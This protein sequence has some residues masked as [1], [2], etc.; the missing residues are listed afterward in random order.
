MA[1]TTWPQNLE[2]DDAGVTDDLR[3]SDKAAGFEITDE[4]E[5]FN[6]RNDAFCRGWW[7]ESFRSKDI[8]AFYTSSRMEATPRKGEG[9][10][11]RTLRSGTPPGRS[12]TIMPSAIRKPG[13]CGKGFWT[14]LSPRGPRLRSRSRWRTLR[15]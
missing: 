4:F 10:N 5:R 7:D 3:A 15:R 8:E 11:Q 2:S 1:K 12:P 9:F 6:Q 14:R 13:V